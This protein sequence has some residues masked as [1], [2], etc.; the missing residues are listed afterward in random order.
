MWLSYLYG[1]HLNIYRYSLRL[2]YVSFFVNKFEV[3]I[4]ALHIVHGLI[5]QVVQ[6][7]YSDMAFEIAEN[8]LFDF[9]LRYT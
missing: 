3:G 1:M 2:K 9:S 7:E 4:C 8:C 5:L 6:M